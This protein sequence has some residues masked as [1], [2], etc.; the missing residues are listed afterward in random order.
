MA[1]DANVWPPHSPRIADIIQHFERQVRLHTDALNEDVQVTNERIGQLETVK[2]VP[3]LVQ[4]EMM[5][6]SIQRTPSMMTDLIGI[7][8]TNDV[9]IM[10]WVVDLH[11]VR[12]VKMMIL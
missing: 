5:I 9:I 4:Q 6:W 3:L 2:I 11:D 8:D 10:A 12:Y 7:D 1:E